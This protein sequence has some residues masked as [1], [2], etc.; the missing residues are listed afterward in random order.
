[1]NFQGLPVGKMNRLFFVVD[2]RV[3]VADGPVA[4]K[5]EFEVRPC[6]VRRLCLRRQALP[7]LLSREGCR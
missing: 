6:G 4:E 1:M 2:A 7:P 3:E 5:F